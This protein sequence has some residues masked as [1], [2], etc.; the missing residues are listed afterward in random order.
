VEEM[1]AS[2]YWPLG[3]RNPEFSIDMVNVPVYGPAKGG[4]LPVFRS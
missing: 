2:N 3:K 1:V 4:S